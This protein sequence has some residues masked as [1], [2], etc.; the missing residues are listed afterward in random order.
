MVNQINYPTHR[1]SVAKIPLKKIHSGGTKLSPIF[2]AQIPLRSPV[3]I[4]PGVENCCCDSASFKNLSAALVTQASLGI[5][6]RWESVLN[7]ATEFSKDG[8]QGHVF[9]TTKS[10]KIQ[11]FQPC[12]LEKCNNKSELVVHKINY[13]TD[14]RFG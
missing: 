13:L 3:A 2:S 4:A 9:L 5:K 1:I 10:H 6:E 14:E 11:V 7:G 8:G 12:G